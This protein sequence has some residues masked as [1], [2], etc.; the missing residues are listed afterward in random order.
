MTK[1]KKSK[2]ICRFCKREF[3]GIKRQKFCSK[4]CSSLFHKRKKKS[5]YKSLTKIKNPLGVIQGIEIRYTRH[6][7]HEGK[8]YLEEGILSKRN[9]SFKTLTD[10]L[11]WFNQIRN[12]NIETLQKRNFKVSDILLFNDYEVENPKQFDIDFKKALKEL[13]LC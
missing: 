11:I 9:P 1:H 3:E 8:M 12:I 4:K 7:G 2:K 10:E 5:N 13:G 6:V